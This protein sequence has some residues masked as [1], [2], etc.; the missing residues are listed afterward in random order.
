M[1]K[2]HIRITQ[3]IKNEEPKKYANRAVGSTGK[4][5]PIDTD[6]PPLPIIVPQRRVWHY[7]IVSKP[8]VNEKM[9]A[10]KGVSVGP[11]RRFR[12]KGRSGNKMVSEIL[13]LS[14]KK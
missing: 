8:V 2:K 3:S 11:R 7:D 13:D 14:K 5:P 10:I 9:L 12:W 4:N 1:S 6:P